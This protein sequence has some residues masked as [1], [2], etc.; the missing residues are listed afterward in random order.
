MEVESKTR[1]A[2][3]K[4]FDKRNKLAQICAHTHVEENLISLPAANTVN[5]D[6]GS[7]LLLLFKHF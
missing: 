2:I 3:D 5:K 6:L 1:V 4:R 7:H